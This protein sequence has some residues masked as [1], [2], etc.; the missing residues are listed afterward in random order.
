VKSLLFAQA[1]GLLGSGLLHN[2]AAIA[3]R[4]ALS[5]TLLVSRVGLFRTICAAW[6]DQ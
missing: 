5:A 6:A 2:I 1:A 4:I 3:C